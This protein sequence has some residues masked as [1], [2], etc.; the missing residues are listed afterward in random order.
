MKVV[1]EEVRKFIWKR[2]PF[3]LKNFP[4]QSQQAT[5]MV[6]QSGI[7]LLLSATISEE[8]LITRYFGTTEIR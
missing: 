5:L 1:V 8:A 2:N 4:F 6:F 3:I 7:N